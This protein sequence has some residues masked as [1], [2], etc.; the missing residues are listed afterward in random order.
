MSDEQDKPITQV[1]LALELAAN[2][3]ERNVALLGTTDERM[4]DQFE[5]FRKGV[6]AHQVK[7]GKAMAFS[8]LTD[9]AGVVVLRASAT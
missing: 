5:S 6:H 9:P 7:T 8:V 2:L 3:Y 1:E 4:E